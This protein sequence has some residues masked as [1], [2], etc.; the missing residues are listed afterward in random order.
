MSRQAWLQSKLTTFEFPQTQ[1]LLRSFQLSESQIE[2]I[3]KKGAAFTTQVIMSQRPTLMSKFGAR[4]KRNTR[5]SRNDT[6][7]S[8]IVVVVIV[9][10]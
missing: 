6:G 10:I 5:Q 4:K 7:P 3:R 1:G 9:V 8:I 2:N